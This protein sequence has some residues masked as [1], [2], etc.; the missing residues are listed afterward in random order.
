MIHPNAPAT[1]WPSRYTCLAVFLLFAIALIVP[2]GY[3]VGAAL[4]FLGGLSV[5]IRPRLW[6]QLTAGDKVLLGLFA[7]YFFSWVLEIILDGQPSKRF[8]KPVRILCAGIALFWLLRYPP[9]PSCLWG[10]TA[11]GAIAVGLWASWQKLLLGVDRADGYTHVIQFGNIAMLFGMLCLIGVGWAW[12]Y[13]RSVAWSLLLLLGFLAGLAASLFSGSRGGW[14]GAP[15]VLVLILFGYRSM[16]PR[17]TLP[18]FLLVLL[19][20][21][22]AVVMV[23]GTGVKQRVEQAISDVRLYQ[24]EDNVHTSVG[25]RF[26]MWKAG[27][28]ALSAAP[29]TGMGEQGLQRHIQTLADEDK[30]DQIVTQFGHLHNEFIDTA[31]RRGL[32]GLAVLLILYLGLLRLFSRRL[33]A[34]TTPARPYALAG[35]ALCVS[36]LDY[37][38]TQSFLSHNSGVMVFFFS[39]VVFWAMLRDHEINASN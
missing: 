32:L 21:L 24:Q 33:L 35:A 5:L 11:F 20:G 27:L 38:L 29:L 37:G 3:S 23:P 22:A 6:P 31:A 34:V 2:S 36:Y 25:A 9:K 30:V 1:V 17:F 7:L 4:L 14:I 18:I 26:E 8:D 16:L 39:A 12:L 28:L 19:A 15:F 13:R 10:G